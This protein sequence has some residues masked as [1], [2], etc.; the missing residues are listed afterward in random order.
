MF[1]AA[2]GFP[3]S[4]CKS[5]EEMLGL[6]ANLRMAMA[7]KSAMF[8]RGIAACLTAEANASILEDCGAPKKDIIRVKMEALKQR[9]AR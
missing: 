8:S 4:A 3:P 9:G 2:Y 7:L 1:A 5:S 6:M